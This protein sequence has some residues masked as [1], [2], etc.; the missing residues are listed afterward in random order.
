MVVQPARRGAATPRG[1]LRPAC[2]SP[3][4]TRADRA[5]FGPLAS[6]ARVGLLRAARHN[7]RLRKMPLNAALVASLRSPRNPS[8]CHAARSASMRLRRC[9]APAARCLSVL[10]V[11]RTSLCALPRPSPRSCAW[12]RASLRPGHRHALVCRERA[13][14][15]IRRPQQSGPSMA[16]SPA[17]LRPATPAAP[18]SNRCLDA[19][20]YRR[21]KVHQGIFAGAGTTCQRCWPTQ[22]RIASRRATVG[23]A[24][25][26]RVT[27]FTS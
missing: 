12:A 11:A 23:G 16:P 27:A 2:A 18:L 24:K 1:P 7:A 22:R 9:A 14:G 21:E 19:C 20:A 4:P 10:R 15:F 5:C 3:I 6:W 17:G 13:E 8:L 25:S 26:R